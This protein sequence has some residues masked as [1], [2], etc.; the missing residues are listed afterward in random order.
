ML[1]WREWVSLPA[2]GVAEIKAKVDTGARSSAV[3]AV[4]VVRFDRGGRDWVAFTVLPLQRCKDQA[5][6]CSA[7]LVDRREVRSSGG[8][9]V[10]RH[11]IETTLRV[12][13]Q[14]WPIEVTLARRDLMG[15]R[16]LLGR[17]AIRRRFL[18]DPGR[19]YLAL[20]PFNGHSSNSNEE[21][22]P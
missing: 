22:T 12:G 8:H 21:A 5:V 9:A 17:T 4:D 15:F 13:R 16:L 19:S 6:R 7:P 2:L 1:G 10:R 20:R 14:E 11:V 18:V 3:H